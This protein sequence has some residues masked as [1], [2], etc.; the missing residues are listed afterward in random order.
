MASDREDARRTAASL[1]LGRLDNEALDLLAA[2]AKSTRDLA[3]RL[4]KDLHWTE[5]SALVF[6]AL[7]AETGGRR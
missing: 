7:T 1:G 4:P 3:A 6:T 2:G 5:E